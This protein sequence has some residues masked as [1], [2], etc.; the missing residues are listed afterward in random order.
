MLG[1]FKTYR[2]TSLTS[3]CTP[4]GPYCRPMPR[5]IGGSKGGRFLMGEVPL[6][7]TLR[8]WPRLQPAIRSWKGQGVKTDLNTICRDVTRQG[9]CGLLLALKD[10]YRGTSLIGKRPPFLGPS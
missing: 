7:R 1:A 9:T 8:T 6:Q 4:L 3:K 5:V 10:I 2:G